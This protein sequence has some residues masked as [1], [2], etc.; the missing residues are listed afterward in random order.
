MSPPPSALP[1]LV[2]FLVMIPDRSRKSGIGM[3]TEV[4]ASHLR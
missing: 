3:P 1:R 4:S 2:G